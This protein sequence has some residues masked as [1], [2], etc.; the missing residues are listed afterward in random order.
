MQ[1]QQ[2]VVQEKSKIILPATKSGP[3]KVQK[4]LAQPPRRGPR[5]FQT[6]FAQPIVIG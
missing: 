3:R 6:Y 5:K 4:C 1:I 2:N